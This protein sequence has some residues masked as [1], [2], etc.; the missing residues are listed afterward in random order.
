MKSET[1]ALL[2]LLSREDQEHRLGS[3]KSSGYLSQ[4][5]GNISVSR[6]G[7]AEPQKR[8]EEQRTSGHPGP[9]Q[10]RGTGSSHCR[11]I[12]HSSNLTVKQDGVMSPRGP[13]LLMPPV[14]PIRHHSA[15][16]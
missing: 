8:L 12:R 1:G 9:K 5:L 14:L 7:L 6:R 4:S 16:L 13:C 2:A 3:S 11:G 15:A 10:G